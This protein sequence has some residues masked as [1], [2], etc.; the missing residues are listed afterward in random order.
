VISDIRPPHIT[1]TTT[2]EKLQQLIAYLTKLS[3]QLQGSEA[4]QETVT[5]PPPA[6]LPGTFHK[7]RVQ[8]ALTAESG[9]NGVYIRSLLVMGKTSFT[10]QTRF[11]RW[12]GIGNNRQTFLLMSSLN[13]EPMLG[14]VRVSD[15]GTCQWT[16][17]GGITVSTEDNGVLRVHLPV[18]MYD[19]V[20]VL[21]PE[22]FTA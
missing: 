10:L 7:L 4:K 22:K 14:M 3:W 8:K 18:T 13:A 6:Q 2:E 17:T 19:R 5:Q 15:N 9:V 21:S 12:S 11:S 20:L 1:G 16:G